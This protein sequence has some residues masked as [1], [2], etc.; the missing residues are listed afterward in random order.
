MK[1]LLFI[2][3]ILLTLIACDDDEETP[4]GCSQKSLSY[5]NNKGIELKIDHA[6][7]QLTENGIGG[8]NVNLSMIGQITG[9][10]A[11]Y[12]TYG[13]GLI[14]DKK[15]ELDSDKQFNISSNISFTATSLPEGEFTQPTI[16]RVFKN[17]DTLTVNLESCTLKY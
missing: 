12:R 10:S 15:M 1:N 6:N 7:W 2:T 4:K 11:T 8:G 16:I 14:S 17:N 5:N 13:D 9:D 3:A